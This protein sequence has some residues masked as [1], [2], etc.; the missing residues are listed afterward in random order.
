MS[1]QNYRIA[2]GNLKTRGPAPGEA[3]FHKIAKDY[4]RAG[5]RGADLLH[6]VF[7]SS[8]LDNLK[9]IQAFLKEHYPA[10]VE[11]PANGT[12]GGGAT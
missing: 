9:Q 11:E 2:I 3:D 7:N 6:R 5:V 1:S 8:G 12:D 4:I 10:E